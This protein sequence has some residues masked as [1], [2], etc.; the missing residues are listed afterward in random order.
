MGDVQISQTDKAARLLVAAF[1]GLL[2]A[3]VLIVVPIAGVRRE[4]KSL[5]LNAEEILLVACALI[6][7]L[8]AGAL[9]MRRRLTLAE[10]IYASSVKIEAIACD[11]DFAQIQEVSENAKRRFQLKFGPRTRLLA[12]FA[13]L[14]LYVNLSA[15]CLQL[16]L[17]IFD[18]GQVNPYIRI[19]GAI[20]ALLGL[21]LL[22][23]GLRSAKSI[24]YLA[25]SPYYEAAVG[26][27]PVLSED[28]E[29]VEEPAEKQ[30]MHDIE[31]DRG[32]IPPVSLSFFRRHPL[33]LGWFVFMAGL[34][35]VFQAWF[36]LLA[37]PG[38]FICFNWLFEG[39]KNG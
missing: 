4:L 39:R 33:C 36:P 2:L 8:L 16:R 18:F 5:L 26:L 24:L 19:V 7:G 22:I 25:E 30:A 32:H 37:I 9:I 14:M 15:L 1:L 21:Y 11:D 35:L 31:V 13:Y 6:T 17:G 10:N 29:Q 34:P 28:S 12:L 27:F 3:V 38:V 23:K 20:I